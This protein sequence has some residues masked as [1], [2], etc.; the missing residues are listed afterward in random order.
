ML[1]ARLQHLCI[2]AALHRCTPTRLKRRQARREHL[3]RKNGAVPASSGAASLGAATLT[4]ASDAALS[5][6]AVATGLVE[7]IRKVFVARA[8]GNAAAD[9]LR[10]VV[11]ELL[12]VRC[13]VLDFLKMYE[14]C[15][16]RRRWRT[17]SNAFPVPA[18]RQLPVW[19]VLGAGPMWLIDAKGRQM[20]VTCSCASSSQWCPAA[21]T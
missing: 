15:R 13:L 4:A 1:A 8:T 21:A 16:N 2:H 7:G 20:T 11:L 10:G 18:A 3:H 5:Q 19:G 12:K 17:P 9:R 6:G 14:G